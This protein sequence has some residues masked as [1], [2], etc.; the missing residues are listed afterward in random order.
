MVMKKV[1]EIVGALTHSETTDHQ[2]GAYMSIFVSRVES[3][4]MG[5][6]ADLQALVT[7][8]H[9]AFEIVLR[10]SDAEIRDAILGDAGDA[11]LKRAFLLG[12][13]EFITHLLNHS[14]NHRAD[15]DFIPKLTSE[16]MLS[17]SRKLL[18]SDWD[19]RTVMELVADLNADEQM[20]RSTIRSMVEMGAADFRYNGQKAKYF[21]THAGAAVF[22]QKLAG[23]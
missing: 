2:M 16:P 5:S 1:D 19:G 21:L 9:E 20:I 23:E 15:D 17:I 6:K 22:K 11:S 8:M 18:E 13:L 7:T 12:Q 14:V 4:I 3:A 10:D